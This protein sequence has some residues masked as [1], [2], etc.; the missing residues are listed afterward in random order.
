MAEPAH[1][2]TMTRLW[3][4]RSSRGRNDATHCDLRRL[5]GGVRAGKHG[6]APD[7]SRVRRVMVL[8]TQN[9]PLTPSLCMR[10]SRH[11]TVAMPDRQH[12]AC[13]LL[14]VPHTHG[15]PP[16]EH[17]PRIRRVPR[18]ALTDQNLLIMMPKSVSVAA[19][20]VGVGGPTP[21]EQMRL[22]R[23]ASRTY[24]L[25]AGIQLSDWRNDRRRGRGQERGQS[26]QGACIHTYTLLSLKGTA[27]QSWRR[28]APLRVGPP[29]APT[30]RMN[31]RRAGRGTLWLPLSRRASRCPDVPGLLGEPRANVCRS[32]DV[33]ARAATRKPV[34]TGA[35]TAAT[36]HWSQRSTHTR[37][38]RPHRCRHAVCGGRGPLLCGGQLSRRRSGPT[39]GVRQSDHR[40]LANYSTRSRIAGEGARGH[41]W[42]VRAVGADSRRQR[43]VLA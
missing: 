32:G 5:A 25:L 16:N 28:V 38:E 36:A 15:R 21:G 40:I 14:P 8:G 42:R 1:N 2:A 12:T 30:T 3:E 37:S 34:C 9:C 41:G 20:L 33:P 29:P 27:V 13:R 31:A 17:P 7:K 23:A 19:D 11:Q 26:G 4:H 39:F 22:L 43:C 6:V 24:R 35:A 10:N 18:A